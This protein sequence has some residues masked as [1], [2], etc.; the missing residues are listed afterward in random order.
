METCVGAGLVELAEDLV[1][2]PAGQGPRAQA[3]WLRA[4]AILS[5]TRGE[6][7]EARDGY[8][9]AG[10]L[11]HGIGLQLLL[12]KALQGLGRCLLALGEIDEG[13]ARLQE[14]RALWEDMKA[15]PRIAEI[16]ELLAT[17]S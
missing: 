17:I 7:E 13:A 16:D 15:A 5:E 10:A 9:Q 14:A 2:R 11:L 6:F 12:A 4:R 1:S 8:S 3:S